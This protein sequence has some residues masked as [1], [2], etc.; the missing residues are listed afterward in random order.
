[1]QQ[2]RR[3][4]RGRKLSS[5]LR[6]LREKS[7][8]SGEQVA[9]R[10]GWS[11]SKVSRIETGRTSVQPKELRRLL[12]LY[13]IPEE[14]HG[15]Y[16]DLRRGA[17]VKGWWDDY[18]DAIPRDYA[19]YIELE[20]EASSVAIFTPQVVTGI[21][22]TE[23]YA[24]EIIQAALLF[25][26]PGEV[27]RRIKVRM[28]RQERF[29]SDESR[30]LDVVLD[31]AVLRRQIGTSMTMREQLLHL[32]V[33]MGRSNINLQV[34]SASSGAHPSTAGEFT[35]LGFPGEDDD[36][37]VHVEAMTSSLYVE[38]EAQVFY[39]RLAYNRLCELA[40]SPAE[41]RAFIESL[42]E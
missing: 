37:V 8:M 29:L 18:A 11:Q 2:R 36:D 30:T 42:V 17:K 32:L 1:M 3:T 25:S 20:N 7:G 27:K 35:I 22:Q 4:V 33:L 9:E 21:L 6:R 31:E 15:R 12:D 39:Y 34:L 40:L 38:E 5:E 41:S 26:P 16:V 23:E 13:G 24:R 14:R 10:L 28:E 19:N